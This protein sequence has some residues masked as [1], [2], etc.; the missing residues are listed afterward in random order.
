[1][2][3]NNAGTFGHAGPLDVVP[4]EQWNAVIETTN[5]PYIGRG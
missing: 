1:M 5:V 2:L 3:V 4:L